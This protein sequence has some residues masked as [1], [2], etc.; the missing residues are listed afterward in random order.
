[1]VVASDDLPGLNV[2]VA[3]A[4]PEAVGRWPFF[5]LLKDIAWM[6]M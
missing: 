1:M 3:S 5:T 6:Q 4:P 2:G